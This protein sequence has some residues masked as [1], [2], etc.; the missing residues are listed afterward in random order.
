[1]SGFLLFG[2]LIGMRLA[3]EADH[4]AAVTILASRARKV[5]QI[6]PLGVM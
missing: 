1:M 6:L 5:R 4:V 3:L 2:F